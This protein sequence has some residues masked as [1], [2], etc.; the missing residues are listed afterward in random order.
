MG[1]S[2]APIKQI[3]PSTPLKVLKHGLAIVDVQLFNHVAVGG[4]R[5]IHLQ[6]SPQPMVT[7]DHPQRAAPVAHK[8]NRFGVQITLTLLLAVV[9]EIPL[10]AVH[11]GQ[12]DAHLGGLQALHIDLEQREAVVG[13]GNAVVLS[14]MQ[15]AWR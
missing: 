4:D 15:G 3:K 11:F 10:P 6:Q 14:E 9:E 5:W 8:R 1:T 2:A 13:V 7:V 12:S